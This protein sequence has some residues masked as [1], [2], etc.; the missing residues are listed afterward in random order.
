MDPKNDRYMSLGTVLFYPVLLGFMWT[1]VNFRTVYLGRNHLQ[2]N[3]DLSFGELRILS[4][5]RD[6]LGVET[7]VCPYDLS[8]RSR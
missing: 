2:S 6:V 4:V 8:H 3:V 5:Q 1:L 7:K